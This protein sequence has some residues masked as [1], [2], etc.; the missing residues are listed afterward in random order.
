VRL[1][2]ATTL[3]LV[4]SGRWSWSGLLLSS[5]CFYLFVDLFRF[6][7]SHVV[8]FLE[9]V[10]SLVVRYGSTFAVLLL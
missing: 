4:W 3:V 6:I 9:D 1:A 8:L 2:L 7:S 5:F 10:A